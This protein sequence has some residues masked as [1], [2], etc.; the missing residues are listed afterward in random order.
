MGHYGND[1]R[2]YGK[3]NNLGI[4]VS[5]SLA[6]HAVQCESM[7]TKNMLEWS[8]LPTTRKAGE[9]NGGG[10]GSSSQDENRV[11]HRT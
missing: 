5:L 1:F 9:K 11:T 7:W 10:S 3:N 4:Y 6:K 8:T 2:N